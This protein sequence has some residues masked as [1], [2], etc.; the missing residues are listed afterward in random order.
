LPNILVVDDDRSVREL[1]N[2]YLTKGGFDVQTASDGEAAVALATAQEFDLAILDIMLPGMDGYAVCRALQAERDLP[3]IFLTARDDELEP[4]IGLELGADDY[5][6]KPFNAREL[7]ARVKAVLRRGRAEPKSSSDAVI[8]YPQFHLD[9]AARQVTVLGQLVPL[10]PHE[11]DIVHLLA[12]QPRIV[13][14]RAEIIKAV[15]GYDETYGD[16]RTVDT[17]TKR[18]R[19]K[20]IEAGLTAC[21]I[22]TVWGIGYRF[23]VPKG[24][25]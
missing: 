24:K 10:T 17:H 6:T 8:E 12:G 13:H 18:A 23:A 14:T 16:T 11:F 5:V 2:L 19:K 22:E 15:W 1:V 25:G 3:V 21:A 9:P 7:V 20:L 4:I